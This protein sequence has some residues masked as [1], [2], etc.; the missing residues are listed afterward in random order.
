MEALNASRDE[1]DEE[2]ALERPDRA[3]QL[4][5]NPKQTRRLAAI[6]GLK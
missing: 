5:L 1:S 2:V 6:F 4:S 3:Q